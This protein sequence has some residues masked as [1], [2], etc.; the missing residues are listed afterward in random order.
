MLEKFKQQLC[1]VKAYQPTQDSIIE[2]GVIN[3]EISDDVSSIQTNHTL[4]NVKPSDS[5]SS[6]LQ[7]WQQLKEKMACDTEKLKAGEK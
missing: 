3:I 5:H 2:N 1:K 4:S 6:A 7:E